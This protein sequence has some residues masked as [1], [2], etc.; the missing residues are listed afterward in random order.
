VERANLLQSSSGLGE[1]NSPQNL[2]I[3]SVAASRWTNF[4]AETI[5]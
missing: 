2:S 5:A 4:I 1:N 3:G